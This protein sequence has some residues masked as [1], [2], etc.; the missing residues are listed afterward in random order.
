MT[1]LPIQISTVAPATLTRRR[2]RVCDKWREAFGVRGRTVSRPGAD[3]RAVVDADE[4][5]SAIT[6]RKADDVRGQ[7]Q[8]V[9]VPLELDGVRFATFDEL[10]KGF[11]RQMTA[12]TT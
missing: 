1:V 10:S 2:R 3:H 11:R 7:L 12:N 6:V 4:Q 5:D 8:I 9:D